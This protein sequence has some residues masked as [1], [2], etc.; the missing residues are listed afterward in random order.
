MFVFPIL[1]SFK[2]HVEIETNNTI[3][4]ST[5]RHPIFSVFP[6]NTLCVFLISIM[7]ATCHKSLLEFINVIKSDVLCKAMELFSTHF[8]PSSRYFSSL[9]SKYLLRHIFINDTL[10]TSS[11]EVHTHAKKKMCPQITQ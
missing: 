1:L 2:N 4:S 8:F 3:L 5:F 9:G 7:H 6:G 10:S 11:F